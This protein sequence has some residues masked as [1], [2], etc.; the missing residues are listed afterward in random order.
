MGG[1]SAAGAPNQ[2]KENKNSFI[3]L[4]YS[5]RTKAGGSTKGALFMEYATFL[6]RF[7]SRLFRNPPA[8]PSEDVLELHLIRHDNV[9]LVEAD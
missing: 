8:V 2:E 1:R 5:P 6:R 9:S 3:L 7:D 4:H